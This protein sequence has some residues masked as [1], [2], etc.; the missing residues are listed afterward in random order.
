[1]SVRVYWNDNELEL[2]E[3]GSFDCIPHRAMLIVVVA[4][5]VLDLVNEISIFVMLKNHEDLHKDLLWMSMELFLNAI[6]SVEKCIESMLMKVFVCLM[7]LKLVFRHTSPM[8]MMM[9]TN[10]TNKKMVDDYN[11]VLDRLIVSNVS[12]ANKESSR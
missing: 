11:F 4:C 8:T 5:K 7:N 2:E 12:V 6:D 3:N 9:N 10:E 1:M